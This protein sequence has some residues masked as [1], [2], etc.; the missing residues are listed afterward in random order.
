[1]DIGYSETFNR[2]TWRKI[3][4]KLGIKIFF[5][6]S[7]CGKGSTFEKGELEAG[8]PRD[9]NSAGRPEYKSTKSLRCAHCD[10]EFNELRLY[11]GGNSPAVQGTD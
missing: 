10:H 6:C 5:V 9:E 1:M 8:H 4:S 2:G 11:A 3:K 7:E